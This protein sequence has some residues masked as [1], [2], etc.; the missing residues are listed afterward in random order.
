MA[1]WRDAVV[2]QIYIRAFADADG[3]GV[4]DLPGIT[5]RLPYLRDLGVDAIWITPFY[6]SPMA[7]HGYDVADHRAVDPV[8]G[9][10]AAVDALLA[11]AHELG[12]RVL[13]DLVPN[14]SSDAHP[15][16]RAALAAGPGSPERALY[17]FRDGVPA[18]P[19]GGAPPTT[20]PPNNWR[21]V[22]GGPAWTPA[23]DGR[24]DPQWYLHLFAREQPD[25]NWSHPA[26]A[27]DHAATI[28]FWLDRGADGFRIDV[29]HGLVKDAALRGNPVPDAADPGSMYREDAEP[30]IWDQDGVHTVYR[31]W[32]SITDSYDAADGRDRVLVG[33]AWVS[34]PDRLAR[35]VRP[36][37]L[38]QTFA[39][40]LLLAPFSAPAWRAAISAEIAALAQVG[41]APTWVLANH[42]VVRPATRYAPGPGPLAAARGA[43]RARAALLALLALPGSVYLY[44]G[45]EL[46][47]PQVDVPPEARRDPIW[48]RSGGAEVGRDGARVP[49]PWSGDEPPY[50]FGPPGAPSWLPQ[51]PGWGTL[52]AAAQAGTVTSTLVLARGA[53]ALRRRLPALGDGTLS[54][55][56]GLPADCLAFTRRGAGAPGPGQPAPGEPAPIVPAGEAPSDESGQTVICLMAAGDEPLELT[57]PGRLVLASAPVGYDGRTLALPPDTTVWIAPAPVDGPRPRPAG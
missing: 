56:D 31:Q 13:F 27:A 32:R 17:V 12:L 26:V 23:P 38:H 53:L 42:D 18:P 35:Y 40:A 43:A 39:F 11:R 15:A 44:Q 41:A 7:D 55:I 54:W 46:G 19:A 49:L 9:D 21:S 30:M 33:E 10:L 5:S 6:R 47:L 8:F 45:D 24:D 57:L 29:A 37:E 2:Y 14:H 20:A 28:R 4:G 52:S 50:G 36:D 48:F 34:D 51:P 1:W 22:F 16:F 25:W 3:D